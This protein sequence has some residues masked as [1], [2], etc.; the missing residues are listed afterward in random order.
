LAMYSLAGVAV[1]A[2]G[3]LALSQGL[4]MELCQADET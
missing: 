3:R 1:T 4:V 2:P